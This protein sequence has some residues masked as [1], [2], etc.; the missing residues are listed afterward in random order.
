MSSL[1]ANKI[2]INLCLVSIKRFIVRTTFV[3]HLTYICNNNLFSSLFFSAHTLCVSNNTCSFDLYI[4]DLQATTV[5]FTCNASS[6]KT[7]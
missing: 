1:I 5:F 2:Q 3:C 7:D 4:G 6:H